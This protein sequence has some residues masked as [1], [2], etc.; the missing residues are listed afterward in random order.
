MTWPCIMP[1][2]IDSMF[3]CIRSMWVTTV[4]HIS[5]LVRQSDSSFGSLIV[6]TIAFI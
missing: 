5:T 4:S 2:P 3:F 6:R 1:G